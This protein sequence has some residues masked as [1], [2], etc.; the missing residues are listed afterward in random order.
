[1]A[2]TTGVEIFPS[3]TCRLCGATLQIWDVLRMTLPEL[4][5]TLAEHEN[6]MHGIEP[7]YTGWFAPLEVERRQDGQD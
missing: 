1:M 7:E 3:V 5:L 6:T 4:Y 2:F